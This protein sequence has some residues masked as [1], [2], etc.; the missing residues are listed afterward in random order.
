MLC[1]G[2]CQLKC[3]NSS[4]LQQSLCFIRVWTGIQPL[5]LLSLSVSRTVSLAISLF[6]FVLV[7]LIFLLDL[8]CQCLIMNT[9]WGNSVC[10][11][12]L[13]K[14]NTFLVFLNFIC[15]YS[16]QR[17][18]LLQSIFPTSFSLASTPGDE[19]RSTGIFRILAL[20]STSSTI[21]WQ[22]LFSDFVGM[23]SFRYNGIILPRTIFA[24]FLCVLLDAVLTT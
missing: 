19:R 8:G 17:K 10:L 3:F 6:F 20:F 9:K 2:C 15:I 7:L 23:F 14:F 16:P 18:S 5:G 12:W 1:R 21:F 22:P 11:H 13:N 24:L 4:I